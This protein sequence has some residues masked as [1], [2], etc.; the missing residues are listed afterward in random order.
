MAVLPPGYLRVSCHR[1]G[2]RGGEGGV[3]EGEVCST[4]L[5][6]LL[7]TSLLLLTT[8]LLFLLH[9]LLLSQPLYPLYPRHVALLLLLHLCKLVIKFC[10]YTVGYSLKS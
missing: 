9:R 4:L 2:V 5:L 7:A 10:S 6:L 8:S 1:H 3:T